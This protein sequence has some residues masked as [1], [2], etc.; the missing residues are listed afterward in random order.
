MKKKFIFIFLI[1]IA[2]CIT[3]EYNVGT[4]RSDIIF[5]STE[6]EIALGEKLA[7]EILKSFKVSNNPIDIKRV[8][9]IGE[10]I[11]SVCDRQEINYYFYVVEADQNNKREKNAFSL[12]GGYIFIFKDLLDML[13]D[14]ELAFVLAHEVAHV[15][16]RHVIK[17]LQAAMGYNL[18]II[19]SMVG[20]KDPDFTS[21]LSFALAQVMS[22]Y[23]RLDEFNADELAVKY[24]NILG[25]DPK[26]GIDVLE[27]LY[28]E[29][30]KEI[31]PI[32]YFRTHPYT[33][34]RIRHIKETLRL[35]LSVDDYIN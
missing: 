20:T 34:E 25:I 22:A 13:N 1:F 32:S 17:K 24:L 7:K 4:R 9:S 18:L 30:K 6:K 33:A 28:R 2:G 16:S 26:V 11:A 15:V 12:P 21:G 35:P 10:K 27:K 8:N 23:S 5:Y 29:N 31:R 3:T 19:G 14:N